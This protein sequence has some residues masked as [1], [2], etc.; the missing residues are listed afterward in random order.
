[1]AKIRD[2]A[3]TIIST[4]GTSAVCEMPVHQTGDLLV[5]FVG[6][7][8][9]PTIN[10]PANWSATAAVG[11]SVGAYGG[12]YTRRAQSAAETVTFTTG[13][14]GA[15]AITIVSISNTFGT[16]TN[17]SDALSVAAT[18]AAT[19]SATPYTGGT[20]TPAHANCLVL[21]S[22]FT[23]ATFGIQS[24]PG[25]VSIFTGDSGV[26][27]IAVAYT[28]EDQAS[29]AVTGPNWRQGT[30]ADD[31]TRG[32]MIAIR[33]SGTLVDLDCYIDRA[34]PPSYL[35]AGLYGS[36]TGEANSVAYIASNSTT[37]TSV[38]VDG[39]TS[40]TS[41]GLATT[42]T[43]D[44]GYNPYRSAATTA[45][46]S[47]TTNLGHSEF[48]CSFNMTQGTGLFFGVYRP[49]IPRDYIDLGTASRGGIYINFTNGTT[50][51]ARAWVVGG[52]FSATTKQSDYNPFV[53]QVQ[54]TNN[55]AYAWNGTVT[56]STISRVG[57]GSSSYY[58]AASVQWSNF[59]MLNK[60]VLV[61][62]TS[63]S[64]FDISD[65]V[66]VINNG[67]GLI[68]LASLSGSTMT[69]YIPIQFGGVDRCNVL[70]D[71]ATVQ[72]PKKADKV[73]YLDFHVDN[74]VVGVEFYGLGTNDSFTF[75][76]TVFTSESPY[77]W[78]FNASSS[79][80]AAY[81]FDGSSV[82]NSG[83]VILRAVTTFNNMS[84]IDCPSI[85]Q[86][87]ASITNTTFDNSFILSNAPNNISDC[88]FLSDGVGHAIEI[89]TPGTYTFSGNTFSG[90]GATGTT[91][92]AIYNNSGGSVTI[93]VSGGGSVPTYR[94]GTSAST[95][96]NAAANL[97]LTGLV[98][99]T[100]VRA[101]VG[102]NPAT[103]TELS[104]IESSGTS[105][106]FS[107]SVAGQAGYIQIFN[108][109]YQP[110]YLP[111]TYSGSDQTIPVQQITDRNYQP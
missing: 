68:P 91:D 4:A 85:T 106:N 108:V 97:T 86:N 23:D 19:D 30:G 110:V 40:K 48:T 70:F 8:G 69:S 9:T 75:K 50:A 7:D 88:S 59:Y 15:W 95:T 10:T 101:Y 61:G 58:G 38:L 71:L 105:F 111:I 27:S 13:T 52:Q 93:N 78:R 90:Y 35:L 109:A 42:A 49:T 18:I 1:M 5:A 94:N 74:N 12:I 54:Q 60:V 53:I 87:S 41:T 73:D 76:N 89:N 44:S 6:K 103:S 29:V 34:T 32:M 100:E 82:I 51:N 107:H 21:A 64:P 43:T 56:W 66:R 79:A 65:A 11:A 20:V 104:G 39:S 62:G 14:A 77:Y 81:S 31:D 80:S 2:Y 67:S 98:A 36:A 96:V 92:A 24:D 25:W 28:V 55:T 46:S 37:L 83:S 63:A 17:G 26:N 99:G 22:L 47:S 72:F 57:F 84:F 3:A 45:G 16:A 102:T 33:D